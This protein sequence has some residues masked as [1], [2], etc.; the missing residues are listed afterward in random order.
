MKLSSV[1]K[2]PCNIYFTLWCFYLLQ[3]TLY[4]TGSTISQSLLA[5]ILAISFFDMIKVVSSRGLPIYFKGLNA[6]LLLFTLYGFIL[7]LTDGSTVNTPHEFKPPTIGYLRN[8]FYSILPI[9]SCYYYS[10]KGYLTKEVFQRWVFLFIIIAV[11]EFF[12]IRREELQILIDAGSSRVDITNNI[13]YNILLLTPCVLIF[14]KENI[15]QY[16]SLGVCVV[17][18]ILSMKRGAMLILAPCLVMLI[19]EKLK[20]TKRVYRGGVI[21]VILILLVVLWH[22]VNDFFSENDFFQSRIEETLS[23]DSSGRDT[24]YGDLIHHYFNDA[25]LFQ[26]FFGM[27][28][29]G[30]IKVTY[31]YA[32]NDWLELLTN[33]GIIGVIFFAYYWLGVYYTCKSKRLSK[34]SRFALKYIFLILFLMTLF[35]MSINAMTI[36]SSSMLGYALADGFKRDNEYV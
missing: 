24:L 1:I 17:F 7:I 18:I 23:G 11:V 15:L 25:S 2:N 29:E 19:W 20:T 32:H 12:R 16:I 27:G 4:A 14:N 35:S 6:L 30:T 22:F 34:E 9:Y 36:Y 28:A 31:N 5:L 13:G 21:I 33:Q 8:I 10:K 26:M 3:G